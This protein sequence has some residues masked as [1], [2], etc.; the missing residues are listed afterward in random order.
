MLT[1]FA[2]QNAHT[3]MDTAKCPKLDAQPNTHS[4]IPEAK[5]PWPATK[6]FVPRH[7]YN[8]NNPHVRRAIPIAHY[9]NISKRKQFL[10]R[11]GRCS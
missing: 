6:R 2:S 1:K 9:Y 10:A 7:Y 8:S 4:Q 11:L 5:C 3:Q